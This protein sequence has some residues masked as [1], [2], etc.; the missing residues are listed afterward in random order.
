MMKFCGYFFLAAAPLFAQAVSPTINPLPSREFGQPSLLPSGLNSVAPNLVEGRELFSPSSIAFDSSVT[1]PILYIADTSNNRVLA[2]Q[3]PFAL[4]NCGLNNPTC[5]FANLV[6][7]QQNLTGTLPGGPNAPGLSIGFYQPT[8]IAVDGSGN[9]YVADQQNNRILRFPAPFKQTSSLI[10]PDL[11]I[12][13]VDL[14]HNA[15]NQGQNLPNSQ[16]L[17]F[18]SNSV[19]PVGLAFD[20]SGNLWVTDGGN[21]RV[22]RFPQSQLVAGTT[23]TAD[24]VL[25]QNSFT[26]NNVA[27]PPNG[28]PAQFALNLLND[29]LGLAFDSNGNLYVSD[30]YSRVL[31]FQAPVS[32]GIL[33]ARVLGAAINYSNSPLANVNSYGLDGV[34][35]LAVSGNHLY[36][37]DLGDNRIVE[38]DTP[39]NWGASY[40]YGNQPNDTQI[41]PQMLAVVG[42]GNFNNGSA[43]EG[44][45]Q[46]S[47]YTLAVPVAIAFNGTDMWV[48]DS[49][50]NRVLDFPQ[51]ASG[52]IN[53]TRLV[54]QLDYIYSA[55]NLIEGREVN[56]IGGAPAGAVAIDHNS[57]PPHLYVA[58]T[59][60]NR[61]LCFKDARSVQSSSHADLVLG[62]S[63]PT[64]FYDDEINS[65]TNNPATPTQTGLYGPL[66]IIVDTNGDLFVAD[67]GNG[68]VVRYPAP[69][70]QP[71]GSQQLPNLVLGQSGFTG[72]TITD[73]TQQN[74]HTPWG[75]GLLCN[76][77]ATGQ[78]TTRNLVV[79][80]AYDNRILVFTRPSGG[81][82]QNGQNASLVLG[83][84]G[85]TSTTKSSSTS[86]LN[87]PTHLSID[88]SDRI[89][90]CDTGN[91]RVV[92]YSNISTSTNGATQAFQLNGLSSPEGI[93]VTQDTGEI[94]IAN[95]G[96]NQIYRFPQ[97]TT[98]ILTAQPNN[99]QQVITAVL[100]TQT[101]PLG[102]ALDDSDNLL[103]AESANRITFFYAELTFASEASYNNQQLAPGELAGVS[104]VGLNFNFTQDY[105]LS[106]ISPWPSTE[107]ANDL[108]VLINGNPAPIFRVDPTFIS[109]Q[110]PTSTPGSGTAIFQVVHPSTGEIVGEGDF[111]MSPYQ[112][113]FFT[114]NA[115]GTGQVAAFM[116]GPDINNCTPTP[117]CAINS[118]SYPIPANGK[119][120]ISFCLTGGGVFQGGPP[121]GVAP[122]AAASTAVPPQLLS[123]NG[124]GASGLVPPADVTYSGAGCGFAG[125]WQVN[126]VVPSTIPPGNSNIIAITLG[127]VASTLGNN[128]QSLTVW[129]ATK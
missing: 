94:W 124:F 72:P 36:A 32:T 97:Y 73:A 54:G 47:S 55:A 26:T 84:S 63:T 62:Q 48:V 59:Y 35:G 11:I 66:G 7:G 51:Q 80:D 13:Q 19:R 24:T 44:H 93:V 96:S 10:Q 42:Q 92:F 49:G 112:P 27:S 58:D 114:S 28:T 30:S 60:N 70:A 15:P 102:L 79:S 8:G 74:M 129:F 2:Y 29:P 100:P 117:Q 107:S 82:F 6:I 12:G 45:A 9:V 56:F 22:L 89:Y 31:Y 86:G 1:P 109:F 128:N 91:N 106:G 103:V 3:N 83:Q 78:C 113:G 95:T 119:D 115:Q 104:R 122:T 34:A 99:Y 67:G 76:A 50:N 81:D 116:S 88:S 16:S 25:G 46:A 90:L 61:I 71:S 57:N 38:Y 111:Q 4:S 110:V 87:T 39:A 118:S 121:D 17:Y 37:T 123:V 69:F 21:N 23:P 77:N 20:S 18:S 41:S 40:A 43:N 125:G 65:G 14:N 85:F 101:G 68:R 126:F 5:G 108:E 120:T 52:Y 53:A 127:D 64:D 33:A 75:I 105:N 98:I